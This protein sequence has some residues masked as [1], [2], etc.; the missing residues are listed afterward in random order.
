M[1]WGGD[2][3][4]HDLF[5]DLN[6]STTSSPNANNLTFIN[7]TTISSF[8]LDTSRKWHIRVVVQNSSLQAEPNANLSVYDKTNIIVYSKLSDATGV[9]NMNLTELKGITYAS[10]YTFN[11]SK[12]GYISNATIINVTGNDLLLTLNFNATLPIIQNVTIKPITAYTNSS[13]NCSA[14]YGHPI[15]LKSN[16][17]ISWYNCSTLYWQTTQFNKMNNEVV[18]EPL[19]W[20]NKTGLVGYWKFSEGNGTQTRDISGT[21][22]NGTLINVKSVA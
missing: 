6:I 4:G 19:T 7:V 15:G 14:D 8:G 3:P 20:F 13:L 10:N 12:S 11:I 22:N 18:Q 1:P 21:E 16:I 17:T 2:D 9:V 5:Y